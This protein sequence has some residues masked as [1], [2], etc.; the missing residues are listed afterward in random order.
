MKIHLFCM[1]RIA[2]GIDMMRS[3]MIRDPS[4]VDC[5]SCRRTKIFKVAMLASKKRKRGKEPQIEQ[6]ELFGKQRPTID[7]E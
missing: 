1:G 2:R 3:P 7:K 6:G 5:E 4:R